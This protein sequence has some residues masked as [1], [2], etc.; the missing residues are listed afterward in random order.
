VRAA[1]QEHRA[2]RANVST[3]RFRKT[4]LR[5]G[6]ARQAP[7]RR[8]APDCVGSGG[9]PGRPRSRRLVDQLA[10]YSRSGR[11]QHGGAASLDRG[12]AIPEPE[13]RS[14]PGLLRRWHHGRSDQ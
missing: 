1:G 8:E 3:P 12:P 14:E 10:L 7:G 13:W 2:A 6:R 11:G 9:V 5:V 4:A